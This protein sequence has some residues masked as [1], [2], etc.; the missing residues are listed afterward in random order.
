[1]F[2]FVSALALQAI[3]AT[4]AAGDSLAFFQPSVVISEEDRRQLDRGEV[5]ARVAPAGDR[6]VA[7]FAAVAVRADGDRLVAWMRR[8]EVLKKSSYVQAIGRFSDPPSLQDLE[9]LALED[10]ELQKIRDCRRNRCGLKLAETEMI[11]LQRAAAG[12]G[13]DWK[14]AVQQ[15]FRRLVLQRVE[16]YLAKGHA[17]LLPYE[18]HEDRVWPATR[19][20]LLL[21]H[22]PFLMERVPRFAGHLSRFPDTPAPDVES[23]VYWSKERLGSRPFVSATHVSILRGG[24]DTQLPDALIASKDV[25]ATHYVDASLG[26]TAILRGAPGG[27]NYL[28]Y[29]NRSEVDLLGGTFGGLLRY[30]VQRRLRSEAPDVLRNFRQRIESGTPDVVKP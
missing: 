26:L 3:L 25:F 4:P 1:M 7:V 18:D 14:T 11:Q 27:P 21:G 16:T 19:F 9:G 29:L 6:E 15:A 20:S 2:T 22:S 23:F 30:F 28:A 13:A 17:A 8:I 24:A 5:I 12:A 10:E